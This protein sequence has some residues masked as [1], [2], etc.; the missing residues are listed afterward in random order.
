MREIGFLSVRASVRNAMRNTATHD[1]LSEIR[2]FLIRV[3]ESI[4]T[5]GFSGGLFVAKDLPASIGFMYGD[6]GFEERFWSV[7]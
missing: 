2:Q 1:E 3:I 6:G 7:L 5:Y 4:A